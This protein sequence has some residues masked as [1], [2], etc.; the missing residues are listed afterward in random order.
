MYFMFTKYIKYTQCN[1][2]V[3]FTKYLVI[4]QNNYFALLLTSKIRN[5]EFG[6]VRLNMLKYTQQN[7]IRISVQS[8]R[9]T[10]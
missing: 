9:F 4:Y 8:T 10:L 6:I 2:K 7:V 5:L 3:N 1:L